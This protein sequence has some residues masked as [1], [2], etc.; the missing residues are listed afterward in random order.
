MKSRHIIKILD[1]TGFNRLTA[2]ET[3]EIS[4][5]V[6]DCR[7]CRQAWQSAQIAST[8]LKENAA[9][10]PFAPSPF[11][12]AKMLNAWREKQIIQK[13]FAVLWRWWQASAALVILMLLT[14]I[15]L[16]AASFAAA[17]TA[18]VS[19]NIDAE[20][21]L[22]SAETVILN[23]QSPSSLTTEQVFEFLDQEK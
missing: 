17:R 8:L 21:D 19:Q 22:Y 12:Q 11:F 6:R 5:H 2:E 4:A 13:P 10:E 9:I 18:D 23:R 16:M 14:V 3:F 7:S 1:R 20:A 15:G